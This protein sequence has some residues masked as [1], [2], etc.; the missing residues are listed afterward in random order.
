MV[1]CY[2]CWRQGVR[3]GP[4][5][6]TRVGSGRRLSRDLRGPPGS[7]RRPS[8]TPLGRA[9]AVLV[10]SRGSA[11]VREAPGGPPVVPRPRPRPPGRPRAAR[12]RPL[13]PG[14][15]SS[16]PPGSLPH[17]SFEKS[18]RAN[19]QHPPSRR[20]RGRLWVKSGRG[21]SPPRARG[22]GESALVLWSSGLRKKTARLAFS[23]PPSFEKSSRANF[24][25]PPSRSYR[26][27]C[28]AAP[29]PERGPKSGTGCR[30]SA[31]GTLEVRGPPGDTAPCW[32]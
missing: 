14:A 5:T 2:R 32:T 24:Q 13:A 15:R 10:V 26:G 17:A 31:S 19:F 18:S 11:G 21:G 6:C 20:Y 9:T 23:L 29:G 7:R 30:R 25:H 4:R 16:R 28:W 8:R 1:I 12:A 27:R 3:G 22:W